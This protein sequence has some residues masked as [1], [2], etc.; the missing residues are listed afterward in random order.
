MAKVIKLEKSKP[1][2]WQ[3]AL[4]EF[5]LWKQA[6]GV[7]ERTLSDYKLHVTMF[8]KR[9]P[10]SN[11][12]ANLKQ[13]ILNYMSQAIKPN[14]YNLRLEYL[15]GFFNWALSE[16]YILENPLSNFKKRKDENR[17]VNID[18]E[19]I[20]KLLELPKKDTFAGL[21]DYTFFLLTLDT[22]IRP[23]EG[24]SLLIQDINTK[25]FEIYIRSDVAKTKISRTLPISLI[26]A[27]SLKELINVRHSAWNDKVPVLCSTEGNPLNRYTWGDRLELYS[28]Q[29]SYKIRPYD[30][31]HTFALEY[32]R[33]GGNVFSLQRTLGHTDIS[34]TKRYISLTNDDLRL[35]HLTASPLNLFIS[36][37]KRI[38]NI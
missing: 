21:R 33:N 10:N 7:R 26:T 14:T 2:D 22:G 5:L 8:F 38:R 19:I 29:L 13:N 27:Q 18:R 37:K 20:I 34:M 4:Q 23:K 28:K 3:D 9:Y 25:G 15:K 1:R 11:E 24:F 6:T 16:G 31:R 36:K 32:L 12:E 17:I 30:L 35:Q